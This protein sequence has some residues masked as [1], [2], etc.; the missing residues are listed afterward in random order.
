ML[1]GHTFD[2]VVL[3]EC[4]QMTEP[5]SLIP[6]LQAKA[7]LLVAAG[8]PCQLPPL[9]AS[10]AQVSAACSGQQQGQ[11]QGLLRPLFKRL[12]D[13]GHSC[14][15]LRTQYRCHPQLSRIPN[16]CFYQ[17]PLTPGSFYAWHLLHRVA[18]V[19]LCAQPGL[20]QRVVVLCMHR[21]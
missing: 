14:F 8:D 18:L 17:G 6:L 11:Q 3:D 4:S 10:P 13:M 1:E 19:L 16:Q 15:L 2:V 7:R 21:C 9:I 5:V 20:C 12:A